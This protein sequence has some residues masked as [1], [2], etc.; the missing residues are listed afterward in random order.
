MSRI[1]LSSLLPILFR[2][3]AFRIP[4]SSKTLYLTFDDGPTPGVTDQALDI[5]EHYGAK[6]TFFVCGKQLENNRQL[7]QRICDEGHATGNHSYSH[8]NGW[9]TST[10]DYLTDVERTHAMIQSKLF[11][12]PYGR[13]TFRQYHRLRQQYRIVVWDVMCGDY[14]QNTSPEKC[15]ENIRK[16]AVPGSIVVFHDSD[17][18]AYNMLYA[19]EQTLVFF[20]NQGYQFEAIM[21]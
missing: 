10:R 20:G 16:S 9:K 19:L 4:V 6:A 8:P 11:R 13:L 21:N 17:K 15:F 1:H 7:F 2:D 5:L 14:D 18:A 3:V 12:P